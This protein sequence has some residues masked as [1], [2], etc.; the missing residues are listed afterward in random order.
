M[1]GLVMSGDDVGSGDKRLIR[2]SRY[3]IFL[4][5]ADAVLPEY[6]IEA[7]SRQAVAL[8]KRFPSDTRD[9]N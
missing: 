1:K 8:L 3:T 6:V 7:V 2:L 9:I 5:S 4:F